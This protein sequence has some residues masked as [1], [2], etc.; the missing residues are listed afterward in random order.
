MRE[1]QWKGIGLERTLVYEQYQ[2]EITK[3]DNGLFGRLREP[4]CPWCAPSH[5]DEDLAEEAAVDGVVQ[6][7]IN[8]IEDD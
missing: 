6:D 2:A 8:D 1:V 4:F 7:G 5:T 3:L